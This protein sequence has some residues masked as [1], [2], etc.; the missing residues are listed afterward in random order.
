MR[1]CFLSRILIP[2]LERAHHLPV[3]RRRPHRACTSSGRVDPDLSHRR[4]D[5]PDTRL[6]KPDAPSVPDARSELARRV[7][8]DEDAY[9]TLDVR[10][11]VGTDPNI[12]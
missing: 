5:A 4:L 6:R 3:S 7:R 12:H 9:Q 11:G 10:S 2:R 1:I 8:I